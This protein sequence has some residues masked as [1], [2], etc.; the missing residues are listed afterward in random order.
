[1]PYAIVG[2]RLRHHSN[3]NSCTIINYKYYNTI[4]PVLQYFNIIFGVSIL[5][6]YYIFLIVI[7]VYSFLKILWC[8]E[9]ILAWAMFLKYLIYLG[10]GWHWGRGN[11]FCN[12]KWKGVICWVFFS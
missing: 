11:H 12:N 3:S 10:K 4:Y 2:I 7:I 8:H 6:Y 9:C 1:M 5:L